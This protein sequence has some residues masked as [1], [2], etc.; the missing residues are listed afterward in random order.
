[1]GVR[2]FVQDALEVFLVVATEGD[3]AFKT[4]FVS[5]IQVNSKSLLLNHLKNYFY[6]KICKSNEKI[7]L[8][9]KINSNEKF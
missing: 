1:V 7:N 5:V 8:N 6:V 2:Q 3:C 4:P 9:E